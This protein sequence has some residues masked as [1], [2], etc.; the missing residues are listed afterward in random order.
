M[1]PAVQQPKLPKWSAVMD[2]YG[3]PLLAISSICTALVCGA[4]A[5]WVAV[6]KVSS[7]A[8]QNVIEPVVREHI[9]T[10]VE[11][12][13]GMRELVAANKVNAE[14]MVTIQ[15]TQE[16][17]TDSQNRLADNQAQILKILHEHVMSSPVGLSSGVDCNP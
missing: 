16:K 1:S 10:Q 6:G 17:I 3:F 15:K 14:A 4:A 7:Y 5:L 8:A 12:R 2:R 13:E 11:T 9:Q